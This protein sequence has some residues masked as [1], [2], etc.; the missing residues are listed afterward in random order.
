M[1]NN[2]CAWKSRPVW[3]K[4]LKRKGQGKRKGKG[5][6]KGAGR[7]FI[8]EEQA[9]AS[10]LWSGED[11]AW[12]SKGKRGKKGSSKGNESFWTGG[13]R[14]D[15]SGKGSSSDFNPH[16]GRGK[17]QK[18]KG[19]DG[20][21]AQ[22]GFSASE[23]LLKRDKA[24]PGNQT[25]GIPTLPIVPQL[26]LQ[27]GTIQG[28]LHGWCQ[29]LWILPTIRRTWFWI[30]VAHVQLDR[31]RQS[32]GSRNLRCIMILRQNSVPCIKFFVFANSETET[33][34]ESC[35]FSFA[36]DTSIFHQS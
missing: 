30:L 4:K 33:C 27:R 18:G 21:Y 11:C 12:W 19:K 9:Q 29:S 16:T 10:E 8:R 35:F 31:E 13:F 1:D 2:E 17:D 3:S 24:I 25:I 22:S 5:G 26:Q 15:P 14:T 32:E 6:S 7:G 20:A 36:D 23:T 34:L 28:T